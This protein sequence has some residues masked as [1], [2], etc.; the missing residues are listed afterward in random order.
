M[1]A[2]CRGMDASVF[3][4]PAG[5]RTSKRR[6]REEHARAVCKQCSVQDACAQF[7]LSTRQQHGVWGG[8][9][10]GERAARHHKGPDDGTCEQGPGSGGAL[11]AGRFPAGSAGTRRRSRTPE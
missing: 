3:F 6:E 10:E 2:A 11:Q 7:A 9:S 8:L 1:F 4:S 5:E